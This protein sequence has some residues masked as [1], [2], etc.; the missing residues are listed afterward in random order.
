MLS[1]E[2]SLV[3]QFENFDKQLGA[4]T[5]DISRFW[6]FPKIEQDLE[7]DR[8]K[9][10]VQIGKTLYKFPI[11][12]R[13]SENLEVSPFLKSSSNFCETTKLLVIYMTIIS[14]D[15]F[16]WVDKCTRISAMDENI[17]LNNKGKF[18]FALG[19]LGSPL[20]SGNVDKNVTMTLDEMKAM[21]EQ[22]AS[23]ELATNEKSL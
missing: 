14:I 7:L 5:K 13:L 8:A 11:L 15:T 4:W 3:S 12:L 22:E 6:E 20:T 2:A 19:K 17:K 23:E 18:C 21:L 9:N 10:N 1:E 16:L